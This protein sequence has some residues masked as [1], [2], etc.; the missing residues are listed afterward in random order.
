M[1]TV[2]SIGVNVQNIDW[3]FTDQGKD[4]FLNFEAITAGVEDEVDCGFIAAS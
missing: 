4:E 2:Y 3:R 1:E